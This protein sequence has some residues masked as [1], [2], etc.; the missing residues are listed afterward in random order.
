[1]ISGISEIKRR[2][3]TK[4][5]LNFTVTKTDRQSVRLGRAIAEKEKIYRNTL[6]VALNG[7]I[8]IMLVTLGLFQTH[9]YAVPHR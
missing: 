5:Y 9:N 7:P 2:Q 3:C 6:R 1:M 4:K 8:N